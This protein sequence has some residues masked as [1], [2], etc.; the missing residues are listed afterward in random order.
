M[1]D[2]RTTLKLICT[3]L[4]EIYIKHKLSQ[5]AMLCICNL[6]NIVLKIIGNPMYHVFPTTLYGVFKNATVCDIK[7]EKYVVCPNDS[8]NHLYRLEEAQMLKVCNVVTFGS[9]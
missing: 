4:V 8:C 9:K 1:Q 2:K 6:I 7:K 3:F 5:S